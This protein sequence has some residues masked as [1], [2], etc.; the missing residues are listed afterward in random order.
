MLENSLNG[1]VTVAVI[2][3][4]PTDT[5]LGFKG[6][7]SNLA[8]DG[9]LNLT[10]FSGSGSGFI[11][12]DN[13]GQVRYKPSEK[14]NLNQLKEGYSNKTNNSSSALKTE[15]K[16]VNILSAGLNYDEQPKMWRINKISDL[17]AVLRLCGPSGFISITWISPDFLIPRTV[18]IPLTNE[19]VFMKV[20]WN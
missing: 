13:N 11:I 2:E 8:Y 7:Q 15:S 18:D 16:E 3:T 14:M 10:G 1:V 5:L 6:N 4:E 19:D 9:N 12:E 20:I 17:G